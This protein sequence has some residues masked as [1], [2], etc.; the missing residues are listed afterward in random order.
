ML[1][2]RHGQEVVAALSLSQHDVTTM[3]QVSASQ[4]RIDARHGLIVDEDA[5]LLERPARL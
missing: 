1:S 2:S 5:S 3:E 4:G